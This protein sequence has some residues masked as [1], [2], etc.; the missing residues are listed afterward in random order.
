MEFAR[1]A[2]EGAAR[3]MAAPA[4]RYRLSVV[5]FRYNNIAIIAR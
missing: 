1:R 5:L 3:M 4:A 2:G